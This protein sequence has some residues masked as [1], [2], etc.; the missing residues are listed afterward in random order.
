MDSKE[1]VDRELLFAMIWNRPA[2][3]VVEE[4]SQVFDK[5]SKSL[6]RMFGPKGNP[7]A[8]NL[9]AVIQYLHEQEGIH[10]EVKAR[11]VA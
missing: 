4:L 1:K 7:Q 3:H 5:S 8:S 10:M 6:K 9:F 2:T 11:K